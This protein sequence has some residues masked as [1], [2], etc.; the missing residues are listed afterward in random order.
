MTHVTRDDPMKLL[1]AASIGFAAGLLFA[2]RSGP[3][4]R[5][6]LRAQADEAK[7]RMRSATDELR[8]HGGEGKEQI[9]EAAASVTRTGKTLKDNLSNT[10]KEAAKD[11]KRE[12]KKTDTTA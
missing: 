11:T 12:T 10:T 9:K 6:R 7:A 5:D 4:T 3:E 2:P 1:V 8:R